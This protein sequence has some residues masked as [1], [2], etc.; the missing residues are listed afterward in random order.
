MKTEWYYDSAA[1]GVQDWNRGGTLFL[2]RLTVHED[3]T[4]QVLGA[5]GV[6]HKFPDTQLADEWLTDE[7]YK[8]LQDLVDDFREDNHP[9]DPRI[10]E[11]VGDTPEELVKQMC[12]RL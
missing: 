9:M 6:V 8:R 4:A 7:E 12:I 2:A 3:G 5:D 10:K 1:Y 11:P